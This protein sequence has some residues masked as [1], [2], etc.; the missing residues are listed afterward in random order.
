MQYCPKCFKIL[1]LEEDYKTP[2]SC[3]LCSDEL[4]EIDEPIL[5]T[6]KL[7]NEK[8]Y[9][10][11]YSCAGHVYSKSNP[12]ILFDKNTSQNILNNLEDFKSIL[13]EG[14]TIKI[15]KDFL[16]G[17]DCLYPDSIILYSCDFPEDEGDLYEAILKANLKF[18]TFAKNIP[19][20]NKER[21][22]V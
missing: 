11:I 6:I 21:G 3:D 13:P 8:G 19:K 2:I 5:P 12:Y 17:E 16:N 18:F 20:F 22:S 1:I 4:V 14:C 9:G 10:T 15:F 7:L